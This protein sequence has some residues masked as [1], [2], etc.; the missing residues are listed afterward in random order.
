MKETPDN[1]GVTVVDEEKDENVN[2][3]TNKFNFWSADQAHSFYSK[4]VVQKLKFGALTSATL[5]CL[6]MFIGAFFVTRWLDVVCFLI[7]TCVD[8]YFI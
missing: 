1:D 8:A 6:S 3:A 2:A 4:T 5:F 7:P